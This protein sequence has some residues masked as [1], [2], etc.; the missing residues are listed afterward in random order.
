MAATARSLPILVC[1]RRGVVASLWRVKWA[2]LC[3][4][5][6]SY[7][8]HSQLRQTKFSVLVVISAEFDPTLRLHKLTTSVFA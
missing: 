1:Q 4:C 3:V 2:K 8:R 5:V 6:Y 7:S